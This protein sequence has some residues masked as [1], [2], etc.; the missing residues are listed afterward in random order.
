MSIW[1]RGILLLVGQYKVIMATMVIK[2]V[3]T[4]VGYYSIV[5]RWYK[6]IIPLEEDGLQFVAVNVIG[7]MLRFRAMIN[8]YRCFAIALANCIIDFNNI[9]APLFRY[10]HLHLLLVHCCYMV[11]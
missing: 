1:S 2:M 8:R 4:C 11:R 6:N 7:R 5:L 10:L 3:V 9:T